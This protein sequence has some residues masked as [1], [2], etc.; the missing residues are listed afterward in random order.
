MYFALNFT[1]A[2]F[3][4]G[5]GMK[6]YKSY[7]I[8]LVLILMCGVLLFLLIN[9]DIFRNTINDIKREG[10]TEI[11][12]MVYFLPEKDQVAMD[13]KP[14]FKAEIKAKDEFIS[15]VQEKED[16]LKSI[17]SA[18]SGIYSGYYFDGIYDSWQQAYEK[19][20]EEY[21]EDSEGEESFS[22][23]L[24]YVNDDSIPELVCNSGNENSGNQILTFYNGRVNVLQTKKLYFTYLPMKNLLDNSDGGEGKYFDNFF[25]IENGKWYLVAEGEYVNKLSDSKDNFYK[26]NGQYLASM[27]DYDEKVS[28][29]YHKELVTLPKTIYVLKEIMA[30]IEDGA[31]SSKGHTYEIVSVDISWNNAR[32][33]CDEKGGY[34]ATITSLE[35]LQTIVDTI[36]DKNLTGYTFFI[37][38]LR[39]KDFSYGWAEYGNIE[40]LSYMPWSAY[41]DMDIFGENEPSYFSKN[42]EGKKIDEEVFA[43]IYKN[44][45][46]KI[47]DVPK[48]Y[49]KEF[50]AKKGK[51]GYICEYSD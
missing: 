42:A 5:R 47:F 8:M 14:R 25:S 39:K 7:L 41:H 34:L 23:G 26:F 46:Y 31:F 51:I 19:Y 9:P 33:K 11:G 38:G 15:D 6:K 50:P 18:E 48:Q 30:I 27:N 22:Y 17:K 45:E 24:I 28:E 44:G 3:G 37:G 29:Y 21:G 2:V 36:S 16:T 13:S 10:K 4:E 32:K 35:E 43:L 12:E 49:L 40:D 20:L 1:R